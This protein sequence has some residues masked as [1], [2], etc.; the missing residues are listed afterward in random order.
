MSEDDERR[1]EPEA[2]AERAEGPLPNRFT[3]G[4]FVGCLG[5]LCVL[6]LPALL[7]IPVE[8]FQLPAWVQR[9]IPLVG[10]AV[11]VFGAWLLSRV[12]AAGGPRV[13]DPDRPLTRSGRAPVLERPATGA[14]RGALAG[15]VSLVACAAAGYV[16]VSVAGGSNAALL[17]GTL[18]AYVAGMLLLILSLLS[19]VNRA[20]APAWRWQRMLAQRNISTQAVP[21]ACAGVVAVVWALFVA[22]EQGYFWAPLGVGLMILAGALTGPILQRLP[23]R[24]GRGE[25]PPG[26]RRP[27]GWRPPGEGGDR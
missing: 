12:P 4:T 11:V 7:A 14:N 17:G 26:L 23:E 25:A 19:A 5:I 27:A 6:T 8:S 1:T 3:R 2:G 21:F 10:V 24:K 20:P 13:G 18:L 9:L 22:S 16:L 15:A